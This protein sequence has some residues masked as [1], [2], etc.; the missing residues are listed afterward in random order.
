MT[1]SPK[2]P[3]V[4]DL[5]KQGEKTTLVI[6][7]D[8]PSNDSV[9]TSPYVAAGHYVGPGKGDA[10][11]K[12]VVTYPTGGPGPFTMGPFPVTGGTFSTQFGMLP[13]SQGQLVTVTATLYDLQGGQVG[14]PYAVQVVVM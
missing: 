12:V 5:P 9:W 6:W 10:K 3:L 4:I 13:S 11:V 7:I 8:Y 14:D 2:E 1:T